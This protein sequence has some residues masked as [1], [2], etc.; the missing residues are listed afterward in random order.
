MTD[1]PLCPHYSVNVDLGG[2]SLC[3]DESSPYYGSWIHADPDCMKPKF[4]NEDEVQYVRV[5]L[6]EG[7]AYTYIWDGPPLEK[8][9]W[10]SLPSNEVR[11]KTFAGKV[12]R[13]LDG[14]DPSY[15]GE[16]KSVVDRLL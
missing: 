11:D 6:D 16:Y 15:D 12:I 3:A 5:E 8:G 1:L 13:V 10:V 14:P 7:R 9:E 2:W 4:M